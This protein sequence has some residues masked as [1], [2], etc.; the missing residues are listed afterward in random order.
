MDKA[1][2]GKNGEEMVADYLRKNGW[3][4]IKQNYRSRFGEIDIIAENDEYIIFTEVKTRKK[5]SLVSGAEAVNSH[6]QQRIVLTAQDFLSKIA[7]D[8]QP[9][10]DVAVVTMHSRKDGSFGFELNYIENAF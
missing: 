9:R 7:S 5:N 1:L 10:F 4:V 6:K 8:L 3:T 2:T